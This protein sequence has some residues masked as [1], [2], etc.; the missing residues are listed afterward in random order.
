LLRHRLCGFVSPRSHVQGSLFRGFP[1]G[2]AAPPR[3]RAV[4]S[5]R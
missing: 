2:E 1:P 5:C 4:P 3:R